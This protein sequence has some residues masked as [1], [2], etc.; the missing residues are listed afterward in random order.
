MMKKML[1]LAVAVWG[2]GACTPRVVEKL[3]YYKMP[4]VQGVPLDNEAVLSLQTGMTR[5]QVK[6]K[7]GEPVLRSAFREN[8]WHYNYQIMRG[9]K[10]K[11]ERNLTIYFDGN[12]VAKI[13][14]S[15]LEAARKQDKQNH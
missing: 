14:G 10:I 3:P 6:L 4:V 13:T 9:G 15:A 8:Q 5:E 2:L 12:V 7:I 1:M 11:E